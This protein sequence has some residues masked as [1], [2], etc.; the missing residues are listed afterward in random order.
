M[1]ERIAQLMKEKKNLN[2]NVD[3]YSGD[4]LPLVRHSDRS[5]HAR[6]SPSR[7]APAGALTCSSSSKTI[8]FIAR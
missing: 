3:F 2:A 1:S 5:F 8:A 4:G 6:S 7:A